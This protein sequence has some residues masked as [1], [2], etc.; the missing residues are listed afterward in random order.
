M[1]R[2][3]YKR[4]PDFCPGINIDRLWSLMPDGVYEKAKSKSDDKAPVLDVTKLVIL[5]FKR[6]IK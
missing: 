1:R 3:H 2:F 5:L 4:N 6:Y